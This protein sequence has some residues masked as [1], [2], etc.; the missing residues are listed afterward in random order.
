MMG[1]VIFVY[2][3]EVVFTQRTL[4]CIW[5]ILV[6]VA[7][8]MRYSIFRQNLVDVGIGHAF[9]EAMKNENVKFSLLNT[10]NNIFADVS[11]NL[12]YIYQKLN[13]LRLDSYVQF[14]IFITIIGNLLLFFIIRNTKKSLEYLN[15]I[16]LVVMILS[17]NIYAFCLSKEPLQLLFFVFMSFIIKKYSEK[18]LSCIAMLALLIILYSLL[19]RT[20]YM[21]MIPFAGL[22]LLL[23][24]FYNKNQKKFW[25]VILSVCG[26]GMV[27]ALCLSMAGFV[28]KRIYYELIRVRIRMVPSNT[29]LIPLFSSNNLVTQTM[30]YLSALVRLMF[31]LELLRLGLKYVIYVVVQLVITCFIL[32][33][34]GMGFPCFF[35]IPQTCC[36]GQIYVFLPNTL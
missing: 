21:L 36:N 14:E 25:L 16:L 2:G 35:N 4:Y 22:S 33:A 30:N 32:N 11:G 18:P 6:F 27:Y 20:Y 1:K 29:R 3:H 23:Y 13:F 12:V 17:V 26:S 9:L 10:D 19:F 34:Y 5:P 28:D 8:F 15:F 31:P 24:E 7:K